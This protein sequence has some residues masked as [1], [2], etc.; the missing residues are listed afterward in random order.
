MANFGTN[1]AATTAENVGDFP[2]YGAGTF[3]S[4]GGTLTDVLLFM[5]GYSGGATFNFGLY[6]GGTSDPTGSS[7]VYQSGQFSYNVNPPLVW[8]SLVTDFGKTVSGALTGSVLT[9]PVLKCNDGAIGLSNGAAGDW[10]AGSA[11]EGAAGIGNVTSASFP[12]TYPT[13][14]IVNGAEAMMIYLVYT[15]AAGGN[16]L[17]P[18]RIATIAAMSGGM[19]G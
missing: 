19:W 5:S 11:K 17:V 13:S 3:P 14:S 2:R 9:W 8:K 16:F 10:V 18:T 6:Q 4:G 1:P 7:L 15:P 12:S